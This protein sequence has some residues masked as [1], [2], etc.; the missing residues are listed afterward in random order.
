MLQAGR[1]EAGPAGACATC[2]RAGGDEDGAV[3]ESGDK[4]KT[5]CRPQELKTDDNSLRLDF[6]KFR[7]SRASTPRSGLHLIKQASAQQQLGAGAS[8]QLVMAPNTTPS[9]RPMPSSR[10]RRG[11]HQSPSPSRGVHSAAPHTR[12]QPQRP[13]K[14]SPSPPA[15]AAGARASPPP[16]RG[17]SAPPSASLSLAPSRSLELKKILR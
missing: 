10:A 11:T 3:G 1:F 4:A 17:S 16:S 9:P 2:G 15:P 6:N 7:G 5:C 14:L 12:A 8:A 13:S